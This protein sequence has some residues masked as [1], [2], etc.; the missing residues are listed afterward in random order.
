M[1]K[2][3]S[4]T[5]VLSARRQAVAAENSTTTNNI[6]TLGFAGGLCIA[7][8]VIDQISNSIPLITAL[9]MQE[10]DDGSTWTSVPGCDAIGG[11]QADGSANEGIPLGAD[12]HSLITFY[13]PLNGTRKRYLRSFCSNNS[14][15]SLSF[16]CSAVLLGATNPTSPAESS[17]V[18]GPIGQMYR[19]T[20]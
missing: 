16:S 1:Y 15:N 11:T 6:D 19:A 20:N 7:L 9:I 3:D 17:A 10:S 14:S 5:P 4:I 13:I 12:D 8:F 18:D 2:F